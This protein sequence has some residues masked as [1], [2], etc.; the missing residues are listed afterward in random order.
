M[1]RWVPQEDKDKYVGSSSPTSSCVMP[2]RF[3]SFLT[4]G[5]RV[6]RLQRL[7]P[8]P[9]GA[10]AGGALLAQGIAAGCL[11]PC[12]KAGLGVTDSKVGGSFPALAE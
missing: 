9:G 12:Q 2:G 5:P 3:A 1:Q 7:L 4:A 11:Q 10:A 8:A 6:L